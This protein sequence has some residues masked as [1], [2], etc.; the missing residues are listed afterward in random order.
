MRESRDRRMFTPG[1]RRFLSLRFIVG[2]G[3]RPGDFSRVCG[4]APPFLGSRQH[5]KVPLPFEPTLC[6]LTGRFQLIGWP[7]IG[8]SF[9]GSH[10]LSSSHADKTR[11]SGESTRS[12]K[13]S[14]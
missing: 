8:Q 9:S 14:P 4:D 6:E 10:A 13:E 12:D 3:R 11:R 7:C 2:R 5:R 1:A